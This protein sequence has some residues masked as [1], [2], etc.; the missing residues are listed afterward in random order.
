MGSVEYQRGNRKEGRRL[1]LSLLSLPK[2]TEDLCEIIDEAGDFLTQTGNY[3]DG[4][5]LFRGAVQAFPDYAHFY[6]GAGCCAGHQGLFD[7]ALALQG[8]RRRDLPLV[9]RDKLDRVPSL[10]S[11]RFSSKRG[12]RIRVF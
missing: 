1:F 5:D 11:L 2:D 6:E 9:G 3:A 12:G 7:E 8:E 4:L 10:C